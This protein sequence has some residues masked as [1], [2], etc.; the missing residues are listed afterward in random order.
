M[1]TM[2]NKIASLQ[3]AVNPKTDIYNIALVFGL[4]SIFFVPSIWL[5]PVLMLSMILSRPFRLNEWML[6]IIGV[7][8]PYYF[9]YAISFVA[10]NRIETV[11]FL[12]RM[13]KPSIRLAFTESLVYLLLIVLLAFGIY[14]VQFNMRRLLVQSRKTWSLLYLW[15]FIG[16][17]I[18]FL[19]RNFQFAD[20]TFFLPAAAAFLSAFFY[21]QPK[22]WISTVLH[23]L[24]L[25]ISIYISIENLV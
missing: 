3:N 20:F 15:M 22:A 21:C 23:W 4:A 24:L 7:L 2:F 16:A 14:Y 9:F 17:I 12:F 18:P 13:Y 8:T 25:G 1:L 5:L 6:M 19:N 11:D 10:G